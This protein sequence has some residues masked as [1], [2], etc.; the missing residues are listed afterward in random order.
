MLLICS[1]HPALAES[2]DDL[3]LVELRFNGESY[4][5]AVVLTDDEGGFYVEKQWL[6]LWEIITPAPS[7]R[8]YAG[9]SFF[10]ID[11]FDDASA[12]L[13]LQELVLDVQMPPR[14]LPTR[15]VNLRGATD[16]KPSASFG[17]FVDYD[18]TYRDQDSGTV[19]TFSSLLRPVVFGSRG[20]VA[21]NLLFRDASAQ[22]SAA[23]APDADGM[24]V[25]DLT[26]T[27]DDPGNVRS[28]RVGDVI[29]R[30]G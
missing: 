12:V 5:T 23:L 28:V 1:A 9:K 19:R 29:S 17:A 20:N 26:Y 22:R 4:G 16:L 25:L 6:D 13:N 11:A 15:V 27:L 18:W 8:Q 30:P 14:H 24:T 3:L 21:A 7:P 10:A 2:P